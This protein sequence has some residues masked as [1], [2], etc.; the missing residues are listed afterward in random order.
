MKAYEPVDI[1]GDVGLNIYGRD[2]EELFTNAGLGLYSLI[3]P[4]GIEKKET[5]SITAEGDSPEGLLVAFL[6]ELI[7]HFD[8]DGFLGGAI[9]ID[10][11]RAT[12]VAAT[13]RGE[14]FDPER[15]EGSLLLKAATYHRVSVERRDGGWK[16]FVM[17]DI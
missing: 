3:T 16:A 12:S 15:H 6:N 1:S 8:T 14:E 5:L 4:S 10:T 2:M 13:V 17:F 9:I 11:I 7:F